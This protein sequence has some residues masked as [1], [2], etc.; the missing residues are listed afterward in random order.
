MLLTIVSIVTIAGALSL[1]PIRDYGLFVPE[2]VRHCT[3]ECKTFTRESKT[4]AKEKVQKIFLSH[5]INLLKSE[6][7]CSAGT[8]QG[9]RNRQC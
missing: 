8:E 6:K 2:K 3:R 1:T 4:L 5:T 9:Q 7:P